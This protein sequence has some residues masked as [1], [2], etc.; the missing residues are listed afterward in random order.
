MRKPIQLLIAIAA[1]VSFAFVSPEANVRPTIVVIDAGHGG[2]DFGAVHQEH[3]EKA[4]TETIAGKIK[5]MNQNADVV[6]R[7]TRSGDEKLDLAARTAMINQMRPDLVLSLHVTANPNAS[8][9]GLELFIS[10]E[11]KA[12]AKSR[13]LAE[14]L[15][16]A[17]ENKNNLKVR[18]IKT[19]PFHILKKSDAPAITVELGFIT[20]PED[21]KYLTDDKEQDQLAK[22]ILEFIGEM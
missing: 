15:K 3:V 4:I 1:V 20:N 21:A 2:E 8:A 16:S 11:N 17:F 6:L 9:R 18:G 12:A 10:E 5:A 19:A 13:E 7:F 14:K 22:T